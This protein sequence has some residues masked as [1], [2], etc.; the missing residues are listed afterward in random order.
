MPRRQRRRRATAGVGYRRSEPARAW[1]GPPAPCAR[2][3][4][5]DRLQMRSFPHQPFR[6][7]LAGG[8]VDTGVGHLAQPAPDRQVRRLAIDDQTFL[9]EPA[10]QWNVEALPQ[11]PDEPL[12]L[13]LRLR[14]IRRAQPGPEP[15]VAGEVE[16]AGMEAV[17]TATVA[18][19]L[20]DGAHIVVQHLVRDAAESEEC[21][22]VR[23]DQRLDTLVGDE[24]DIGG[25]APAQRRHEYR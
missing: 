17:S 5:A 2:H 21:I 20:D 9:G 7:D 15:A 16:K 25:P 22:L 6:R 3:K 4:A 14:P 24:L 10:R 23:R 8:A 12:H 18:V 19:P 11:I 1:P 13:A